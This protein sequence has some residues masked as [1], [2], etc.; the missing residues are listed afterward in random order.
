M[1]N[2]SA[3]DFELDDQGSLILLHPISSVAQ[4]WA[5]EHIGQE[6]GYQP[7][8]P[9]VVI[10]SRYADDIVTGAQRDGLTVVRA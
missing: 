6:N 2:S 7:L 3:P 5:N 10:E 9:T 4:E 1:P 8:W